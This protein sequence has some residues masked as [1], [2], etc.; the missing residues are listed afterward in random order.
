MMREKTPLLEKIMLLY[1]QFAACMVSVIFA[2]FLLVED[3]LVV[4]MRTIVIMSLMLLAVV[5]LVWWI[6]HLEG[7]PNE[8]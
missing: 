1:V 3:V 5:R 4:G 8:T 7:V 6:Y 2:L